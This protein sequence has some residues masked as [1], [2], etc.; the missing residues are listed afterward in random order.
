MYHPESPSNSN[1]YSAGCLMLGVYQHIIFVKIWIDQSSNW[2]TKNYPIDL[3]RVQPE[4]GQ[5][6]DATDWVVVPNLAL[7]LVWKC[8]GHELFDGFKICNAV[9]ILFWLWKVEN[10]HVEHR[11]WVKFDMIF[12]GPSW[13]P[14]LVIPS[15]QVL[16]VLTPFL[17]S[18]GPHC[19]Y[20]IIC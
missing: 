7:V 5:E 18:R 10:P 6:L 14:R 20:P 11:F 12:C 15:L 8:L 17:T 4:F 1:T 16:V 13:R 9:P 19:T 2:N 3:C